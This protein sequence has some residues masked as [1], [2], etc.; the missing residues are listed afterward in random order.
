MSIFLNQKRKRLD[1]LENIFIK[2]KNNNNK[3]NLNINIFSDYLN[4]RII[5]NIDENININ[6]NMNFLIKTETFELKHLFK[7]KINLIVKSELIPLTNIIEYKTYKTPAKSSN[8]NKSTN[9]NSYFYPNEIGEILN[10]K[11][12]LVN[13]INN[14]TFRC[15]CTLQNIQI[16]KY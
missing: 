13:H 5:K 2:Y 11:Y 7:T 14:G 4:N 10:K 15:I 1:I 16:K 8:N 6:N 9:I 12:L 3:D